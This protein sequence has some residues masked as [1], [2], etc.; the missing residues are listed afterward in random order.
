MGNAG[1]SPEHPIGYKSVRGSDVARDGMYLE[2]L[3]PDDQLV[4]EIFYSDSTGK[5]SVTLYQES[6]PVEAIEAFIP[7]AKWAL[8]PRSPKDLID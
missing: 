8:T 6:V 3:T 7:Y 5:M 1:M 2:L 4:L